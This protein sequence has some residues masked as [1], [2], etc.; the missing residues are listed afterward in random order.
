MN[1]IEWIGNHVRFIDQTKLP[2]EELF[3]ETHQSAVIAEAIRSLRIRGAPLIGIAAAYGVALAALEIHQS[4]FSSFCKRI[5]EAIH[6][7][8]STRPTAVNLFW[9]LQRMR[10]V[11]DTDTSTEIVTEKLIQEALAIHEEDRAMCRHIGEHGSQ[12]LSDHAIVLTH[13]NAGALATGGIGTALGI[14]TTAHRQGKSISVYASETRPL[15]QGARLTTWELIHAGVDVTL[16]TEST[17][18]LLMSQKKI[19]CV[20]VGADR[21][22]RNGDTANKVGTYSH[23]VAAT[24]HGIPFYVAAPSS[25]IDI[26]LNDGTKIPIERRSDSEVTE[27]FGQ[28][29]APADVKVFSPAFDVTPATLI[30]AIV[31]EQGIHRPPFE[32]PM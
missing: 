7:L 3:I 16:I 18:S 13:C 27:G 1:S 14:I 19:D 22:A 20:L 21:I 25:S 10:R 8:A 28:R 11:L 31:T 29:I 24:H 17:A 6:V 9:A 2:L 15:L 5:E 30:S 12:L 32:F 4:S 23:A 26:T